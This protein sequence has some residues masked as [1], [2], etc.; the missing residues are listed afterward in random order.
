VLK[1]NNKYI[2]IF[3]TPVYKTIFNYCILVLPVII[4]NYFYSLFNGS[5]PVS[6]KNIPSMIIPILIFVIAFFVINTSIISGLVSILH[7]KKFV[8][9]LLD[10]L[11][12]GVLN[13]IAMTPFGIILF[14]IWYKLEAWAMLI[15]FPVLLARY[16]FSLYLQVK[17]KYFQ[18]VH[19]LMNAM[20]ARD[21]YT[22]GHSRRVAQIVEMIARELKFSQSKIDTLKIASL[23]HD[24]GKIGI[25]DSI[26]NKPGKLTDEEYN[27]IKQHP[28]IGF[29]ILKKVKDLEDTLLIVKHH[30]ERYDGKGYPAGLNADQ[31]G[32]EIFIVQLADSIDAMET[33]RPYRKALDRQFVIEEIK[34]HSGTQFH[35]DVVN[36]YLSAIE[37]QK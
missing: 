32:L 8:Y 23:L 3:N 6:D 11:K 17:S 28:E 21:K 15:L 13:I 27:L 18:T 14:L 16:T 7:D 24:L 29:E 2:H 12:L 20:E 33:N 19:I 26:L 37:K 35:P 9:T 30:H 36:A 4:G 25:D 1:I 31:L 10:N 5:F 22:E 34:T